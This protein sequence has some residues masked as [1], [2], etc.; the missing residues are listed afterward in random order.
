MTY[1]FDTSSLIGAWTRTYPP[2][3]FP[4]LWGEMD[5]LVA[6]GRLVAP[7]EVLRELE[8]QDDDLKDWVKDRSDRM[9]VPASR[10]IM[11]EM[12][13]VLASHPKLSMAGKGRGIADPF[14]IALAAIRDFVVVTQERGGTAQKP[15]IPSV[16][17][18]RG[19]E[20]I[21]MLEVIR[22]ESWS[23]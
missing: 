10:A 18:A 14:V 20:C 23:F 1:V 16:C 22:R 2:D 12:R 4:G 9:V 21:S 7:D 8:K 17:T 6:A 13:D 3:L 19:V 5:G 11:L 15:R